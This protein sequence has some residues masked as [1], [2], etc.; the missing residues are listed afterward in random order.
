MPEKSDKR[1]IYIAT[2]SGVEEVRGVPKNVPL[3]E[4]I[5]EAPRPPR[6][7]RG[8]FLAWTSLAGFCFGAGL[9]ALTWGRML[10]TGLGFLIAGAG[11]CAVFGRIE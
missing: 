11:I 1:T 9:Y 8:Y 7:Y 5:R 4:I 2:P 3:S 6:P 10:A